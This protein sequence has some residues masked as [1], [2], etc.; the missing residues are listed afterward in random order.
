MIDYNLIKID[1]KINVVLGRDTRKRVGILNKGKNN[2][3]IDCAF[4]GLDI[5]IQDEG[6]NTVALKNVIR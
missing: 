1:P 6:E 5:A 2:K 4:E 3:F